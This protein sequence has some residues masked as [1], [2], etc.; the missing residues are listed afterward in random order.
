LDLCFTITSPLFGC[1]V[2]KHFLHEPEGD[3]CL[4]GSTDA[5]I[6]SQS[7]DQALYEF[8]NAHLVSSKEEKLQME[9]PPSPLYTFKKFN[10]DMVGWCK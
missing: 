9:M 2:P 10:S 1:L 6:V 7:I 3:M 8:F 4:L 5:V